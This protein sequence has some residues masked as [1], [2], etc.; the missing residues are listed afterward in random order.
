MISIE[1]VNDYSGGIDTCA[2]YIHAKWGDSGNYP[3]YFDAIR[4][5]SEPGKPLPRFYLLLDGQEIIG[6][7]ALLN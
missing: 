5:S 3:F 1:N 7:Y 6:C 2:R 4:H